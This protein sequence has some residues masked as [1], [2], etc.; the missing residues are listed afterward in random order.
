MQYIVAYLS[1]LLFGVGLGIAGMTDPANIIGFLDIFGEWKPALILVMGGAI[2]FHSVSYYFITKRSSPLLSTDFLIP[3]KRQVDMKL[4][5][6]S[7]IFGI[8]WGTG[9]YCPGPAIA[10][11]VTLSPSVLVFITSMLAGIAVF[12][13]ILKP[14]LNQ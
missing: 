5:V 8:G 9:G 14:K 6:G 10:A 12:Y 11:L 7:A 1:A 4:I 2:A 13:Y 3:A